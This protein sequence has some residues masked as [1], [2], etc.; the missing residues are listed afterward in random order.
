MCSTRGRVLVAAGITVLT[1][2]KESFGELPN[3]CI[4]ARQF[5]ELTQWIGPAVDST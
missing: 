4:D 3:I 5:E 1:N 2:R